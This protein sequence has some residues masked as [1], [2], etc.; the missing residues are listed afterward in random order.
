MKKTMKQ[1]GAAMLAALMVCSAAGCSSGNSG[2][3]APA[4]GEATQAADSSNASAGAEIAMIA[5]GGTIDDR[6][7]NQG[8]Y[9]GVKQYGEEKGISYKYYKP[10]E[11]TTDAYL[12]AMELAIEGGAKI[13][14]APGF[15]FTEAMYIAQDTWPETKFV[16][17]DGI[18]TQN[19]ESKTN[20]NTVG[21][22]Y[23]EE[24]AGFLAGYAAVVEGYKKLGFMG[25]VATPAVVRY[26]YG[27]IQGAEAAAKELGLTDVEVNYYYTGTFDATP[28]TQTLAATW[29]QNGTEII[30]A[31]G[32]G[33]GQ[34]VMAAADASSSGKSIG[35]DI[36]WAEESETVVTSAMKSLSGTVYQMLDKFYTDSFPGGQNMVMDAS[37]EGVELPMATS[38]FEKFDQAQYDELYK[39]LADG[40]FKPL[41]DV[42]ENGTS[43]TLD[44][45]SDGTVK[46]V[47]VK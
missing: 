2:A 15:R 37:N 22:Q 43:Y 8:T 9:D 33:V 7:F 12:S 45:V 21:I 24:Q 41:R 35:V 34:S 16:L 4:G 47:E 29:Y 6:G 17:L 36:D 20:E 1:I 38:R 25:G 30:F 23:A 42:D 27:Y 32:S 13:I 10:V 40:T 14:V 18:P 39:K 46:V 11:K 26:G 3:S 44:Q 19:G 31:C 5:D 28:E